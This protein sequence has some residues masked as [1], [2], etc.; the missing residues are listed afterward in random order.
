[1]FDRSNEFEQPE[2]GDKIN[3]N[4]QVQF[5]I[6]FIMVHGKSLQVMHIGYIMIMYMHAQQVRIYILFFPFY[7][8]IYLNLRILTL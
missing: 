4:T 3:L 2:A 6:I 7:F 1:M 8:I 5:T